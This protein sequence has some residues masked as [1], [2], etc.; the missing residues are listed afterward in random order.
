MQSTN[1]ISKASLQSDSQHSNQ[2]RRAAS[3]ANSRKEKQT[4]TPEPDLFLHRTKDDPLAAVYGK[5]GKIV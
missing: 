1:G 4:V 2:E 3:K 5:T